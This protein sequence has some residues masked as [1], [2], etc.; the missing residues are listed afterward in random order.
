MNFTG[1]IGMPCPYR[2]KLGCLELLRGLVQNWLSRMLSTKGGFF[3]VVILAYQMAGRP[4]LMSRLP[5]VLRQMAMPIRSVE[6]AHWV[7]LHLHGGRYWLSRSTPSVS[8][9]HCQ[10]ISII[11]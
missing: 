2:G 5:T 7:S 3:T 6:M 10:E 11:T 9:R 8:V 1:M 4:F